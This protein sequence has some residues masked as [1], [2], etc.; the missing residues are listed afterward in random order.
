MKIKD[1][2]EMDKD[3]AQNQEKKI[4]SMWID[5]DKKMNDDA[6]KAYLKHQSD[7]A[8]QQ[9]KDWRLSDPEK[10]PPFLM[11]RWMRS[12][13][14]IKNK[15]QPESNI[16]ELGCRTGLFLSTLQKKGFKN[17]YGVEICKEAVGVAHKNGLK[18]VYCGDMHHMIYP[19]NFFDIIVAT[20]I[21]E[22]SYHIFKLFVELK[23]VLKEDG[24][25]YTTMPIEGQPEDMQQ[26]Q[27]EGHLQFFSHPILFMRFAEG[28]GFNCVMNDQNL[29]PPDRNGKVWLQGCGFLLT[30]I[31]ENK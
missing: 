15:I 30:K 2:K 22:H 21:I 16:L 8:K 28:Q 12:W 11:L 29:Y 20:E 7:I 26:A 5:P 3:L 23:R 18:N 10:Q 31:K 1:P 4:K 17:L 6:I 14:G 25:I 27:N 9:M 19:N 13:D 24:L